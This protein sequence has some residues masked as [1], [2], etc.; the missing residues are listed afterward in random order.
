MSETGDKPPP[1]GGQKPEW[2]NKEYFLCSVVPGDVLMNRPA[3]CTEVEE[4]ILAAFFY[5]VPA[6]EGG[7]NLGVMLVCASL[8]LCA[9]LEG[10]P[11]SF[12]AL[13]QVCLPY[14]SV[15]DV[16]SSGEGGSVLWS[17]KSIQRILRY[18]RVDDNGV[19]RH[20]MRHARYV[21]HMAT[22]SFAGLPVSS[23]V[24]THNAQLST[25]NSEV[26]SESESRLFEVVEDGQILRYGGKT[27]CFGGAKR[28]E[29]LRKLI[30]AQGGY[31]ALGCNLKSYFSHNALAKIFFEA[32]VEP[33]GA[34][35]KGTGR[36]RLKI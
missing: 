9:L 23:T 35:C 2:A 15:L 20:M 34:G 27:Y 13:K 4:E 14:G 31:V 10:L 19:D 22:P 30:A 5:Y 16:C 21:R 18:D 25:S 32:A 36:Y 12:S 8:T 29:Y 3:D 7:P 1:R 33:E 17:D 24:G 26:D 11:K 6:P 28:W